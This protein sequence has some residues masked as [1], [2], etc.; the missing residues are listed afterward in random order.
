[1]HGHQELI[2]VGG[3]FIGFDEAFGGICGGNQ[4]IGKTIYALV[5]VWVYRRTSLPVAALSYSALISFTM[6]TP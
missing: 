2:L 5:M 6:S 3:E 4:S 1:M